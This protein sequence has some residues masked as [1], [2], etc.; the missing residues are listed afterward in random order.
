MSSVGVAGHGNGAETSPE[1][2][3][4]GEGDGCGSGSEGSLSR[5][6]RNLEHKVESAVGGIDKK[7]EAIMALLAAEGV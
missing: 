5:R 7:L 6:L 4:E 1:S 3:R 2:R